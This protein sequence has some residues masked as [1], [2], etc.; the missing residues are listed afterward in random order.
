MS[1][2]KDSKFCKKKVGNKEESVKE[3][4]ETKQ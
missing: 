1:V 2:R 4:R 3:R